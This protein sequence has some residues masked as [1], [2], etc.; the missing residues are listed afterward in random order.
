MGNQAEV[1]F[2]FKYDK[3][4][5]AAGMVG[6]LGTNN[7]YYWKELQ[8]KLNKKYEPIAEDETKSGEVGMESRYQAG[9]SLVAP[10]GG[11]AVPVIKFLN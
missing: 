8:S 5:S 4:R 11:I 9:A 3:S 10:L 7:K 6:D 1:I 2:K